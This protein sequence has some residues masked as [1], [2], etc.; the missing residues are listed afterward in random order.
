MTIEDNN[1]DL[2]LL[3]VNF[4]EFLIRYLEGRISLSE[5]LQVN[6]RIYAR[7]PKTLSPVLIT[8]TT[9][10]HSLKERID[11]GEKINKETITNIIDDVVLELTR[12]G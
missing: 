9:T 2:H 1:I 7:D 10:L 8:A 5:V 6:E 3:H 4:L 11:T 12:I